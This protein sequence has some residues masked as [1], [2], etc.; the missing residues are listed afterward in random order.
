MVS[1]LYTI[2]YPSD[3]YTIRFMITFQSY[4]NSTYQY[5]GCE[6]LVERPDRCDTADDGLCKSTDSE[7]VC[8]CKSDTTD[9]ESCA[10]KLL[11]SGCESAAK[12][13]SKPSTDDDGNSAVNT[14][15]STCLSVMIVAVKV[16]QWL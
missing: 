6:E 11:K 5:M 16:L 14:Q 3:G 2:Y 8:C 9:G 1:A 10:L 12:P 15:I 4:K 13:P 7:C